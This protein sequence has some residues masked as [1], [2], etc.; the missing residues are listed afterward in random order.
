MK[1]TETFLEGAYIIEPEPHYDERGFFARTW[2]RQEFESHNLNTNLAQCNLSFNKRR[3]TLR[4][5]HYQAAP[6]Q[7]TK[8][9]RCTKGSIYDLIVDVRPGS[10]TFKK[11]FAVEL[12][13]AN[14]LMLYIPEGFAH[15]FQALE[16][17]T[18]IFYQISEFYRPEYSRGIRWNDAAFDFRWPLE[19]TVMSERD[20]SFPDFTE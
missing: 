20:R 14:H 5:L 7:E 2:C 18:E 17:E 16:D 8:L 15:G 13:A 11:W 6:Y 4:G 3:G 19:E 1:F 12:T 9:V 10:E